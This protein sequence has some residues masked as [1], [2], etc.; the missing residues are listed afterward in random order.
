[1]NAAPLKGNVIVGHCRGM[2]KRS[3]LTLLLAQVAS[4]QPTVNLLS[5][6][7]MIESAYG[8]GTVFSIDMDHREYWITAKHIVN[9]ATHPPYGSIKKKTE[10]LKIL[11]PG[12]VGE[13][14]INTLFSVLDPG[15]DIDIVV[16]AYDHT[17]LDHPM[18]NPKPSSTGVPMGGSCEFLGFPYGGGWRATFSPGGSFWMPYVKH[19]YVSALST[20]EKQFWVLD[21]INNHGFSGG[22]VTFGTG[23]QQQIMAVVS[24]Y[25]TEPADVV[26]APA[27]KLAPPKRAPVPL[28]KGS[29]AAN[30]SRTRPQTVNVNSGFI[31]AFD[32]RYAMEAINKNPIGAL[33]P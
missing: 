29:Q 4:A 32:I 2:L 24:G 23:L 5:R 16:L 27:N 9:G 30:G 3:F 18:E 11:N 14:W 20:N 26:T 31:I 8:R 33:R 15:E 13:Q 10:W 25:L 28:R 17:F 22:P 19:C 1:M 12:P 6:I 7:L 21:G